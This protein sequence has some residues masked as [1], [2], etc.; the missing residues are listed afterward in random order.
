QIGQQRVVPLISLE[1]GNAAVLIVDV[2]E[3][4][5]FGRARGLAGGLDFAVAHRAVLLLGVDLGRVDALHAVGAFF[6]HAAAAHRNVRIALQFQ[7]WR[8]EIAEQE[9]IEAPHLVGAVVGAVTRAHAAVVDHVVEAFGAVRGGLHG[10]DQLAGRVLAVHAGDR[11]VVNGGIVLFALIIGID[12]QPVH[13]ASAAHLVLTHHGDI[14]FRLAGDH[15]RAASG[16]GV[17]VDGHAPRVSFILPFGIQRELFRR[18]L[19]ALV[20][21]F[22]VLP[23]IR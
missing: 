13:G 21:S 15:T 1:F 17:E 8:F 7:A 14:I 18:S 5:G 2:A 4:D 9:E 6:H 19:R 10:A 23:E 11:L 12:A 22:G 20:R 16:A 3:D